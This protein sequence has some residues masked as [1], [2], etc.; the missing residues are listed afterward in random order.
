MRAIE[1][2]QFDTFSGFLTE[3]SRILFTNGVFER[4]KYVFRGQGDADYKLRSSFDRRFSGLSPAARVSKYS[5][6]LTL[7][8]EEFGRVGRSKLSDQD[9]LGLAQHYGTPTRMLDWSSNPLVAAYFA[10]HGNVSDESPSKFVSIWALSVD[11]ALEWEQLGMR[12]IRL[13][14]MENTRAERQLGFATNLG[15]ADDS[16]EEFVERIGV[17]KT[18][19]WRFDVRSSDAK[20]TFA[21]LDAC[22]TRASALF[23][24]AEGA[25]RTAFERLVLQGTAP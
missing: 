17:D 13:E 21:F 2:Y 11:R 6:F 23:G 4:E 24:E 8:K 16:L 22:N 1:N 10:F 15:T 12:L 19:L 18:V 14:S 3:F 9:L 5:T 7:L 25:A 20:A